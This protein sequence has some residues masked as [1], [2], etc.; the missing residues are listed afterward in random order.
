MS[1]V[2]VRTHVKPKELVLRCFAELE[3]DGTWFAM[4]LDLN[5]YARGDSMDEA[6]RKLHTLIGSYL[7]DALTVDK[8][9][10]GDLMPRHA[11]IYFWF[12]YFFI[13]CLVRLHR[14]TRAVKFKEALPLVPAV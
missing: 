9:Y 13:W 10:I 1:S 6:R 14:V 12:R 3:G 8:Q 7:K 11:P 4:C 2:Q 5:L